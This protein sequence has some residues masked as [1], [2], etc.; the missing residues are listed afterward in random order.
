MNI[1]WKPTGR[2]ATLA[3]VLV[4]VAGFAIYFISQKDSGPKS[5]DEF[6]SRNS[7]LARAQSRIDAEAL[8][9]RKDDAFL[10]GDYQLK[11]NFSYPIQVKSSMK[12]GAMKKIIMDTGFD[13]LV[14]LH[15]YGVKDKSLSF[16]AEFK[17]ANL[18]G[19]EKLTPPVIS[20]IGYKAIDNAIVTDRSLLVVM[21]PSGVV[22]A[23]FSSIKA[24]D[25]TATELKVNLLM[26]MFRR[27]PPLKYG[28]SSRMEPDDTGLPYKVAYNINKTEND[29]IAIQGSANEQSSIGGSPKQ[30]AASGAPNL[31]LTGL[32]NEQIQSFDFLWDS[33][34]QVPTQ[35]TFKGSASIT[36]FGQNISNS[37]TLVEL[38]W[39]TA[40]SAELDPKLAKVFSFPVDFKRFGRFNLDR[41]GASQKLAKKNLLGR[42]YRDISRQLSSL[43]KMTDTQRDELFVEYAKALRR[44][45]RLLPI[46]KENALRSNPDSRERSMALGALGFEGSPEAQ[47]A[48]IDVYK[49]S[50][51]T[52]DEKQKVMT[53]LAICSEPLSPSTKDFLSNEFRN[54]DPITSDLAAGAGLALGSS[55]ARDGDLATIQLLKEA[56]K[57]QS[58]LLDS[59]P[60][61]DLKKEYLLAAMGNSKSDAFS[62]Q[63]KSSIESSNPAL[64]AA[65]VNSL[66]FAQDLKSRD[67]LTKALTADPSA[68][69]QTQAAQSMRYQPFDSKTESALKGCTSNSDLGVKL[70]CYRVLASRIQ[71]T[72]IR[73]YLQSRLSSETDVQVLGLLRQAL[74]IEDSK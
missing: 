21:D 17:I 68:D 43:D 52:M 49:S 74:E 56:W 39:Q 65:A 70:E 22:K 61:A 57:S 51:V 34:Q 9:N 59:K 25:D 42:S 38:K 36:Q 18:K 66:R 60:G 2:S 53:E 14:S 40:V 45:R 12:L 37:E 64:R 16:I 15:S 47:A 73:E 19:V 28:A 10:D 41:L 20:Q 23:I 1:S 4:L 11:N 55:I 13:G 26:T 71:Q 46:V 6:F 35:Q 58:G 27:L 72:G 54:G 48:M 69:V 24:P 44:D 67:M 7:H 62:D 32:A 30:A 63:V 50:N 3:G 8:P 5:T 33:N 31:S 29:Q